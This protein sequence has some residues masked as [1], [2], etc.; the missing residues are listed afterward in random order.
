MCLLLNLQWCVA[1]G[2][3]SD[4]IV[5]CIAVFLGVYGPKLQALPYQSIL[6]SSQEGG[7]QKIASDRNFRPYYSLI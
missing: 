6:A 7:T 5:V 4:G 2:A 1:F 3:C